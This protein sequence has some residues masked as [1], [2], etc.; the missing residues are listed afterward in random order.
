MRLIARFLANRKSVKERVSNI[1]S[2]L[3]CSWF[4]LLILLALSALIFTSAATA[5]TTLST[6]SIVGTV[7]DPTGAVVSNAKVLITSSSTGQKTELTSNAAGAFSTGPLAPGSYKVQISSKGFSTV[8]QQ[9]VVQ[10]GNTA[11]VNASLIVGQES[12]IVEVQGTIVQV[13]T[14]QPTVQGVSELR[15]D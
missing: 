10:V 7:T 2:Q 6:G 12:T 14:E 4:P 1:G 8:S 11:T 5:Q 15:A 9:V 3:P 13:N